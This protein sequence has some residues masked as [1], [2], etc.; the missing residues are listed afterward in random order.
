MEGEK[1]EGEW[2][3]GGGWMRRNGGKLG[4]RDGGGREWVREREEG[5][6]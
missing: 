3:R 6:R 4:W 5:R 1:V 2:A